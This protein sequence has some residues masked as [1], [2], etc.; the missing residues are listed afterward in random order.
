MAS[1][2]NPSL[3]V[4]RSYDWARSANTPE[5]FAEADARTTR[6]LID[7]LDACAF[8]RLSDHDHRRLAR[9][10]FFGLELS[11]AWD[12]MRLRRFRPPRSKSRLGSFGSPLFSIRPA[13]GSRPSGRCG[14]SAENGAALTY[15]RRYAL[16]RRRHR[17]EDDLDAPDLAW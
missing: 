12:G 15:A 1:G 4:V 7:E 11:K 14:L 17:W 6:V 5:G 2:S 13:S 8:E 16:F 10:C 3:K 9:R